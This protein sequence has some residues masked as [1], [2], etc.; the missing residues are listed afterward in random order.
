MGWGCI[1][2]AVGLEGLE[3]IV[4][5]GRISCGFKHQTDFTTYTRHPH[6]HSI[7]S[8]RHLTPKLLCNLDLPA[9]L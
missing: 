8:H 2:V 7:P 1:W 5:I 3:L 9:G 4:H 6:R